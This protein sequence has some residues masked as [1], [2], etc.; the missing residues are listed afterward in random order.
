ME[1]ELD[2][3]SRGERDWVPVL[4]EF[5]KP[6]AVLLKEKEASVTREQAAQVRELG[7]DP[8]SGRPVSARFGRFGSFIQI[9]TREDEEKPRWK[10]L[11]PGQ[12]IFTIQLP[13]ALELF[14]LPRALGNLPTGEPVTANTGQ[15]G[16]Y[17]QYET[18]DVASGEVKKKYVSLVA[19]E[20]LKITLD[21][22]IEVIRAKQEADANKLIK[23]FGVENLRIL[24]GRW[25]PYLTDSVK[26][27]RLPKDREPETV[28]LA[29]A[30][31]LIAN[32]P[33]P[34][35]RW[36]RPVVKKKVAKRSARK[37]SPKKAVP[38]AGEA[39]PTGK[40]VRKKARKKVAAGKGKG[41]L[42]ADGTA[43]PAAS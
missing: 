9:G 27:A 7:T 11:Q 31:E 13:D 33:I 25:G 42:A 41:K 20:P 16:P 37:Y 28:T 26:N 34:K 19:H 4:E 32:A 21:E 18:V 23:D 6:F 29:E 12:S 40:K 35:R 22:A 43:D 5:W 8:K 15:F 36:G 38:A 39:A 14:K 1:D 24:R 17:V 3:V 10:G 30:Q 2:E